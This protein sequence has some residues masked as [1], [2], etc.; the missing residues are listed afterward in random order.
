MDFL[1]EHYPDLQNLSNYFYRIEQIADYLGIE[2]DDLVSD[3]GRFPEPTKFTSKQN[4]FVKK[5][6]YNALIMVRNSRMS[7]EKKDQ[8]AD[9]TIVFNGIGE[10]Q[11][12]FL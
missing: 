1:I 10:N 2:V 12:S 4:Q 7:K 3:S 8:S 9:L 5:D 11:D 6:Y